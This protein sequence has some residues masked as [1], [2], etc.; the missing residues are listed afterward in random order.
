[1]YQIGSLCDLNLH[2]VIC[3]LYFSKKREKESWQCCKLKKKKKL[4]HGRQ[5]QTGIRYWALQDGEVRAQGMSD[6]S[7]SAGTRPVRC[8]NEVDEGK[9]TACVR[10]VG[11]VCEHAYVCSLCVGV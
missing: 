4:W 1:M 5:H 11:V 2:N 7:M 3:L 9:V 10:Y 6:T 8:M